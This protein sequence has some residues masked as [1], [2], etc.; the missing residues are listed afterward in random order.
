ME[1][2]ERKP[3][4]KK[5]EAGSE[6]EGKSGGSDSV[7]I[8]ERNRKKGDA[9]EKWDVSSGKQAVLDEKNSGAKAKEEKTEE[10]KDVEAE[11]NSILKRSPSAF[12]TLEPF[13]SKPSIET[14]PRRAVKTCANFSIY[15]VIIF[16]KS[17]CPHSRRAKTVFGHYH[18]VP[19][20]FIVEL[21]QHPLGAQIQASL[22][23]STGR[24]TVPNVL[25]NGKSI[26]G[27]DEVAG[28]HERGELVAK[29]KSMAGKRVLE[30]G[31]K[32][33]K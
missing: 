9:G 8:G 18:I 14:P 26:G 12:S 6:E 33:E 10:E 23:E 4:A 7:R 28:L 31:L 13:V 22:K 5:A 1:P 25:I 3:E 17:Y 19:D 21:D 27:G 20:P 30:V 11:L 15:L 16:S 32:D 2:D 24:G 29:I